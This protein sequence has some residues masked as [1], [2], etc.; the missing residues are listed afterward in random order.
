MATTEYPRGVLGL[1]SQLHEAGAE[2]TH[3]KG[4]FVGLTN[5]RRVPG[6]LWAALRRETPLL[7]RLVTPEPTPFEARKARGLV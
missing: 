3:Y 5:A 4:G 7:R 1:L 2:V 6:P